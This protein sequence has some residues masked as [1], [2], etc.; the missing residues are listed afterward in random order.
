MPAPRIRVQAW[1]RFITMVASAGGVIAG[2][3]LSRA[4]SITLIIMLAIVIVAIVFVGQLIADRSPALSTLS[5]IY[6]ST[7]RQ[8][9]KLTTIAS[10]L[11]GGGNTEAG[12]GDQDEVHILT[13]DLAGY[14]LTDAALSV[15]AKNL[16][17]GVRYL[18]YL[19][20]DSYGLLN[21]AT[22]LLTRIRSSAPDLSDRALD[23]NLVF[24]DVLE[25]CIYNFAVIIKHGS[26]GSPGATDGCWYLAHSD[27]SQSNGRLLIMEVSP[28]DA[29]SL[30]RL[31]GILRKA[32]RRS[33]LEMA[34]R[35]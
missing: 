31:F 19:P 15:I 6:N 11:A 7:V 2:A 18:Y 3:F 32:P 13:N 5:S 26:R 29:D 24:Y 21:Q 14:D 17:N 8:A 16:C 9:L 22:S 25:P 33:A 4:R 28:D 23:R 34:R 35:F 20:A 12:V 27:P 1:A 10:F 30:V